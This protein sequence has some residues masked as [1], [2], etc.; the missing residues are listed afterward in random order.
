MKLFNLFAIILLCSSTSIFGIN[1]NEKLSHVVFML[2][3]LTNEKIKE[4]QKNQ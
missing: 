4:L 3:V 1:N 2:N